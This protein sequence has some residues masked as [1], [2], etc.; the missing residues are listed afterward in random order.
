MFR[1]RKK[2]LPEVID[3]NAYVKIDDN[4]ELMSMYDLYREIYETMNGYINNADLNDNTVGYMY[5]D[6]S[7]N[8]LS[9]GQQGAS[10]PQLQFATNNYLLLP[11]TI[12]YNSKHWVTNKKPFTCI[13][14][15]ARNLGRFGHRG[16]LITKK[17]LIY[18]HHS[19]WP[20]IGGRILFLDENNQQHFRIVSDLLISSDFGDTVLVRLDEDVP[21]T[22]KPCV[23]F[24]YPLLY[25]LSR[26][27]NLVIFFCSHS[28]IRQALCYPGYGIYGSKNFDTN[29]IYNISPYW[30]CWNSYYGIFDRIH[31]NKLLAYS[32]TDPNTGIL[33]PAG[34]IVDPKDKK[35]NHI[36]PP[37]RLWR[38]G[39]IGGDSGHMLGFIFRDRYIIL[40]KNDGDNFMNEYERGVIDRKYTEDTMMVRYLN[41]E[42][43]IILGAA[44]RIK[45]QDQ[46]NIWEGG[47]ADNYRPEYLTKY[48]V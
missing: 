23:F 31:K 33:L 13:P 43:E 9:R 2:S 12:L 34:T 16:C 10:Q 3:F 27:P 11:Q 15:W 20:G 7:G 24:G 18:Q 26:N 32:M 37:S 39:L 1:K 8:V 41:I 47:N 42:Y 38:D 4:Y 28:R 45:Y 35:Y 22:I 17:H 25:F 14:V 46:I 44:A 29:T 6:G 40:G 19:G 21:E 5:K 30:I 36:T 48:S